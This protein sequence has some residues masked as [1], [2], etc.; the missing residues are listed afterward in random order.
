MT[1]KHQHAIPQAHGAEVSD[2]FMRGVM[3]HDRIFV[4]GWHPHTAA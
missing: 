2:A 4:L 3:V 1:V